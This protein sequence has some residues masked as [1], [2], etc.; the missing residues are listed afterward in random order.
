MRK[1]CLYR[2]VFTI[3]EVESKPVVWLKEDRG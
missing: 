2:F 1:V 3:E